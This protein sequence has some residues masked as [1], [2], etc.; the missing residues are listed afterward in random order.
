M[1]VL[2]GCVVYMLNES[3]SAG[4]SDTIGGIEMYIWAGLSIVP[5]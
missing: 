3:E 5:C 4:I 1:R 2:P